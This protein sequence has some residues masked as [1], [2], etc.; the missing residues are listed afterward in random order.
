MATTEFP[1]PAKAP[2]P[3]PSLVFR[4]ARSTPATVRELRRLA[5]HTAQQWAIPEGPCHSLALVV[6]E[7]VTNVVLH[8]G[9]PDVALLITFDN[10]ALTVEVIDNGQRLEDDAG[11]P[12]ME[13][14]ASFGLGL[15][16]VRACADWHTIEC[17][18]AG[19]RVTAHIP[20][21]GREPGRLPHTGA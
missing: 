18:T 14:R 2:A 11:F 21:T 5:R 6:S 3:V 12:A 19:T 1:H 7:L 10:F 13:Q 17:T 4:I 20:V 8:S 16:L 15:D 9:S